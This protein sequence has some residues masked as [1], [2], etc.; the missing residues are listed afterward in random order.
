MPPIAPPVPAGG[1]SLDA[2]EVERRKAFL[3]ITAE[4]ERRIAGHTEFLSAAARKI[5]DRF[6]EHL[7]RFPETAGFVQGRVEQLK[8]TQAAYFQQLVEGR[9]DTAYAEVRAHVGRVHERIG[10]APKWYLGAFHLYAQEAAGLLKAS[11]LGQKD[12]HAAWDVMLSLLK[13][14][15]FDVGV[16]IDVYID[17]LLRT[18]K[19][20]EEALRELSAPVIEVWDQVLVLPLVGTM[21]TRRAQEVSES[22]L[23]AVVEKRARVV[24]IDITGLPVMDTSTA[25]HL[26]NAARAVELLGATTIITGV[27]PAIAQTIVGLGLETSALRT[28]ARL[29]DGLRVALEMTGRTVIERDRRAKP[30]SAP[31]RAEQEA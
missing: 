23:P 30:V 16:T 12:P 20:Q 25:H 7:G 11:E 9:I 26:F 3:S 8:R 13:S 1:L 21:D 27:R 2:S 15:F 10:L 29:A 5:A 24:I 18:T 31:A 6:Y 14:I 17:A 22:L 19:A 4:D 28:Q